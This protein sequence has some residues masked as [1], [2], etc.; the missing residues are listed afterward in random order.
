MSILMKSHCSYL[1]VYSHISYRERSER[2]LNLNLL[3]LLVDNYFLN[4]VYL[5]KR[6]SLKLLSYEMRAILGIKCCR[7]QLIRYSTLWCNNMY[8]IMAYLQV[9]NRNPLKFWK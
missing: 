7:R 2:L 5:L 6:I 8:I 4:T 3:H 1:K 9:Q